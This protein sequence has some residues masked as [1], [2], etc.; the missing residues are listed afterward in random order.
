[1][2]THT[3][4]A[5]EER[6]R[7][8]ELELGID[9]Q[10]DLDLVAT[11]RLSHD[12]PIDSNSP[13]LQQP[14][15]AVQI[16]ELQKKVNK[17]LKEHPELKSL[18]MIIKEYRPELDKDGSRDQPSNEP[19]QAEKQELVSVRLRNITKYVND[20]SEVLNLELPAIP[21][22]LVEALNTEAITVNKAKIRDLTQLYEI[23]VLKNLLVL[24]RFTS[25]MEKE[26]K[27]WQSAEARLTELQLKVSSSVDPMK[28]A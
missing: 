19:S 21:G 11:P 18:P 2:L 3:L 5:L 6:I 23:L 16:A 13:E 22:S 7:D 27:F 1:M 25:L 28:H 8:V 10:L 17:I 9:Q 24:N 4:K 15:I 14:Q 12:K 26:A 20:V